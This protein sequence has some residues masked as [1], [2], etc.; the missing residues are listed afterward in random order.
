LRTV[1]AHFGIKLDS[2][3]RH[4]ALE[5]VR[6]TLAV[7]ERLTGRPLFKKTEFVFPVMR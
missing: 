4:D 3:G 5:D 1:C 7:W 2:E 6:A